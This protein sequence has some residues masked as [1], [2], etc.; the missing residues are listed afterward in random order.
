MLNPQLY[1]DLYQLRMMQ[2]YFHAG[3]DKTPACFD[4]FFRQNPFNGG[5][6]VFAGLET[7][8]EQIEALCFDPESLEYLAQ[9]GFAKDF[10]AYLKG[11]RFQG[12]LLAVPEGEVVFP[13][14]P[15][16]QARGH[17]AE[18][19]LIETFLLNTLNFQSLIATKA[20]RMRDVAGERTLLDFGLRR[21]QGLGGIH[22]TRAAMIGGFNGTSNVYAGKQFDIPVIGTMSHAWVQAFESELSAFRAFVNE[23]AKHSVLLIDTYNTLKQG[24]PAAIQVAHEMQQQGQDLQGVRLDSGDLAY[25]SRKVRQQLDQAGLQHVKIVVSNKL[26][27]YL[28]NSLIQ[29]KA[30]IDSFA[31]GTRLVTGHGSPALDG[32]YKLAQIGDKA[33]L[34]VSENMAKTTLPGKKIVYRYLNNEG[35]L[36]ADAIGID[37]QSAPCTIH[38]PIH[39][40][41]QCP[42]KDLKHEKLLKTVI[43]KGKRQTQKQRLVDIAAWSTQRRKQLDP[44]YHRFNHPHTYKVGLSQALKQQRD[45]HLQQHALLPC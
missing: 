37:G 43:T 38:H 7:L 19:Q 3:M 11:F 31:V 10:L 25:L 16:L 42:L 32:V 41:Q 35:Q 13:N 15:I 2:G 30:P 18:T 22:A 28:I 8:L 34:K 27:E 29:Q 12:D 23:H 4:Y 33:T 20:A 6:V 44:E 1:T 17:L 40:L 24:L 14:T 36:Y 9:L 5:Y 26:D 45:Q 39:A 21:A